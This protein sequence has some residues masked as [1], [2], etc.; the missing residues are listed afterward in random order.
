MQLFLYF[1][2][3]A[4]SFRNMHSPAHK[5]WKPLVYFF[6]DSN[7]IQINIYYKFGTD[8]DFNHW[9]FIIQIY[10]VCADNEFW[11]LNILLNG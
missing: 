1:H 8:V 3:H 11:Y 2:L 10:F 5:W 6:L 9:I 7:S 4:Q